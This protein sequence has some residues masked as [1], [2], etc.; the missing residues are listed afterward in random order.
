MRLEGSTLDALDRLI[1]AAV[2]I[3]TVALAQANPARELTFP[4][5]RV[6]V[7]LG[8]TP[9][10]MRVSDIARRIGSSSPSAS[11]LIRRMERAGLVSTERDESD[12]R[13]TVVRLSRGGAKLRSRVVAH[14][15]RLVARLLH[16]RQG[17]LPSDLESGLLI[18]A[19]TL[20]SHSPPRS[21]VRRQA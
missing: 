11:R 9:S 21:R 18:I 13:A 4:Q 5:W 8:E 10:G 6:L 1:M 3:T 17:T 12:R 2:G 15:R 20:S 7:V 14:R 19:D 16:E